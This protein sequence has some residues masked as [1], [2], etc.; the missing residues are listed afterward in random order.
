MSLLSRYNAT[1]D[2]LLGTYNRTIGQGRGFL[3]RYLP[4]QRRLSGFLDRFNNFAN[5]SPEIPLSLRRPIGRLSDFNSVLKTASSDL[6]Q[7]A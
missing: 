1:R 3:N 5:E 6:G 2:K 4:V 7:L